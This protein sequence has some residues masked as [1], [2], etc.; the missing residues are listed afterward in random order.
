M[1]ESENKKIVRYTLSL[2]RNSVKTNHLFVPWPGFVTWRRQS[3]LF[4]SLKIPNLSGYSLSKSQKEILMKSLTY[5][6]TSKHR[7]I[8]LK[9]DVVEFTKI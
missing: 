6:L 8:K 2:K 1:L 7:I 4:L 5:K 3:K 9:R